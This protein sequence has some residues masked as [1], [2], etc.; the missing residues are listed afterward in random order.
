[1]SKAR[2]PAHPEK[3]EPFSLKE[4]SIPGS[5][6]KLAQLVYHGGYTPSLKVFQQRE[7]LEKEI[8]RRTYRLLPVPPGESIVARRESAKA[9]GAVAAH[10]CQGHATCNGGVKKRAPRRCALVITSVQPP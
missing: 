7:P 1:M 9:F 5:V 10:T 2:I 8:E 6:T 3:A 4:R